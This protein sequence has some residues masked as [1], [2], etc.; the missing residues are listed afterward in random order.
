MQ[1]RVNVESQELQILPIVYVICRKWSS[2]PA[3]YKNQ[4]QSD[5]TA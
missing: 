4:V 1:E 3:I 2:M 5:V